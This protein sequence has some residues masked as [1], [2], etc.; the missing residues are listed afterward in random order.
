MPEAGAIVGPYRVLR[1]LGAGGAADVFLVEAREP[2]GVVGAEGR[3][4]LKL[5]RPDLTENAEVVARFQREARA[6][7]LVH[8]PGVVRVLA[9]GADRVGGATRHY[10]AME[11]VEG[12]TLRSL[13]AAEQRMAEG[14]VR[15]L[16]RDLAGGLDAIHGAGL[17]HRDLKPENVFVTPHGRARIADLGLAMLREEEIRL[18]RTGQFL[19]SLFYAAPEQ[20]MAAGSVDARA[21]LYSLGVL[22]FESLTGHN[23]FAHAEIALV[24]RRHLED[25]PPRA[26]LFV[27][28]VSHFLE[29]VLARLLEKAPEAR[30]GDAGELARVLESGE[31]AVWWKGARARMSRTAIEDAVRRVRG[32]LAIP[33]P[34]PRDPAAGSGGAPPTA[35]PFPGAARAL[36]RILGSSERIETV[37]RK[38]M[39]FATFPDRHVLLLGETGV[40][41]SLCARALHEMTFGSGAPLVTLDAIGIAGPSGRSGPDGGEH[42]PFERLPV[43]VERA[44]GGSI[45]IEGVEDLPPEAQALVVALIGRARGGG[46]GRVMATTTHDLGDPGIARRLR[47]DLYFR[48]RGLAVT[49]PPLRA[50]REDILPIGEHFLRR[51]RA[52]RGGGPAAL[53]PGAAALLTAAPWPG[54]VRELEEV[55][56][57]ALVE[58]GPL[59]TRITEAAVEAALRP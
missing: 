13:L 25:L 30:F 20:I 55:I 24:V 16:G 51:L 45:L 46:P 33:D 37:R 7:R 32:G 50:R 4:A 38:L 47:S 31:E 11:V 3:A 53:E 10:L 26:G 48:L 1:P 22:L 6:G 35:P 44:A 9:C 52:E 34:T 15:A 12:R 19:G 43:A 29:E 42:L 23:P 21:D 2:G 58:A 57:G 17:V 18:T 40:G 5:L 49:V 59:A 41:K 14:E 28:E 39:A 36:G 27:P 56:E 8:H 54:N